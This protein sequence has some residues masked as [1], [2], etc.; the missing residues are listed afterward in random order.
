MIK[1]QLQYVFKFPKAHSKSL[2]INKTMISKLLKS[3]PK[4]PFFYEST[5]Y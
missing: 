2:Q 5:T 1:I 4:S 3:P